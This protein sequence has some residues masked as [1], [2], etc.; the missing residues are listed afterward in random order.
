VKDYLE[1]LWQQLPAQL[2]APYLHVRRSFLL[3]DLRTGETV[4]DLG[5]GA[6]EFT[7]IA[8]AAGA[9][10][11][12]VEVAEAALARARAAHPE[13][14]LRLAEIGGPLPFADSEFE[15]V[16][17]SEVIEHVADTGHF[18]D[19][20]RRVL[21]PGGRLLVTTPAHG[22][23]LLAL[24]GIERFSEPLGDHLHLYSR[25]SLRWV[26]D[27]LGFREVSVR[28]VGGAPGLRRLLL[29]RAVR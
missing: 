27:Q 16:W 3:S 29:A 24:G 12:G 18:L 15:L 7:A 21:T 25:R 17:I 14:D 6:G 10:V 5:C 22:R 9:R 26:L 13:L 20:V 1:D 8:A 4:L 23:A 2:A 11:V 19:E 28:A